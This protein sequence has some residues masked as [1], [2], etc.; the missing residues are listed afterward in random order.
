VATPAIDPAL[1]SP[2]AIDA[3]TRAFNE[4]LAQLLASVPAVN[5]LPPA[6]TRQARED[7]GG[8][9]GPIVYSDLAVARTIPAPD[10]RAIPV[11]VLTPQTVNGVY[12]HIHGGGFT[13]GRA[14]HSD[15]RNELT[16]R[17]ADVAVVSVDY[18]LAPE[19]PFPAGPDDC[20]AVAAW[21]VA[22]AQREFGTDRIVIGGESAGGTLSAS[23]L[24]RLRDRHGYTGWSGANLVY[25]AYDLSMTPSQLRWGERNLVLSGPIM[26][27]F[28]EQYLPGSTLE[29]R[30]NP[31]ISPLYADLAKLPPALFSIGTLDPLL[32][33]SLFMYGRW[34]A[35]G[36]Q[37]EIAI[38]PGG[39]HA[40]D[41][42]PTTLGRR[43]TARCDAF[44]KDAVAAKRRVN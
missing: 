16:A 36:N 30:R 17:R 40:F 2:D 32:D 5:T 24:L 18:R 34:L 15:A 10:G 14:H 31:D 29:G 38:Y 37:A 3:E 21:L 4:Q 20:E 22:N 7:G 42:F 44:I 13:L 43:A 26:V 33:D 35:A 1:F 39:P 23:T 6:V 19:D 41:A 9:F 12:L 25:G 11:R 27:W 8:T 28:S